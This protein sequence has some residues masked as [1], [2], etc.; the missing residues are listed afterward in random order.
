MLK[1]INFEFY[2]TP[3]GAIMAKEANK[4]VFEYK[5]EHKWLTREVFNH[6]KDF[7]TKAFDALCSLYSK[8][9]FHNDLFEYRVVHRFLRCNFGNYD[10]INDIDQFGEIHMENVDCPLA[11][12]CK[13][14]NVVCN[15]QL[16]RKLTATERQ[17]MGLIYKQLSVDEIADTLFISPETVKKHI[18]NSLKRLKLKNQKE[19][20]KYAAINNLFNK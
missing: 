5:L 2:R 3:E 6:I 8:S 14:Y 17:V 12:E 16:N 13:Q 4:P 7:Y 11:G 9:N 10:R 15:P 20:F 1:L 18:S 19:F